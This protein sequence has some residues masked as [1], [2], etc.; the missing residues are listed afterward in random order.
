MANEKNFE[1]VTYTGLVAAG[2]TGERTF[3]QEAIRAERTSEYFWDLTRHRQLLARRAPGPFHNNDRELRSQI[4]NVGFHCSTLA[5]PP[6]IA[7]GGHNKSSG[8]KLPDNH[9]RDTAEAHSLNTSFRN[10]HKCP[11][12]LSS[13]LAMVRWGW[14]VR[15]RC[16]YGRKQRQLPPQPL[17][18][19]SR[20]RSRSKSPR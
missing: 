19:Q 18:R 9:H 10:L 16:D 4:E 13:L 20:A 17:L 15:H 11:G 2:G 8:R 1:E 3:N 7:A 12:N 5:S 6:T 14:R